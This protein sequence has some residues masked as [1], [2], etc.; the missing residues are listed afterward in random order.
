MPSLPGALGRTL[1]CRFSIHFFTQD[2]QE[3]DEYLDIE[4]ITYTINPGEWLCRIS[5]VPD[6]SYDIL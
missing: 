6:G 2:S 3:N 1:V 5:E 4:G